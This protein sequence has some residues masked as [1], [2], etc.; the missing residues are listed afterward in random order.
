MKGIRILLNKMIFA[1]Y[2]GN[3]LVFTG[4]LYAQIADFSG[5]RLTFTTKQ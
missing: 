2:L 1:S 3:I 4:A 5:E